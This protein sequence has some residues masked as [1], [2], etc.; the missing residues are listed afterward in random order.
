MPT[1]E[2][3]EYLFRCTYLYIILRESFI[4]YAKVKKLKKKLR[5]FIQVIVT[6]NQQIKV[7]ET[8]SDV[9]G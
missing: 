5:T 4:M 1:E 6:K 8:S 9:A 2:E 7:I 3:E